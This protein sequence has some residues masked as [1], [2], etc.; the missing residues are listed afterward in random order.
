M[1][2][3][4]HH[5]RPSAIAVFVARLGLLWTP[6]LIVGF[7]VGALGSRIGAFV[8]LTGVCGNIVGHLLTG[9][10]EYRRIMGRPWPKVQP[11]EDEDDW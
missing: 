8:M 1:R 9:A 10:A 6:L 4:A 2:E 11:L 7:Y 5:D 3:M